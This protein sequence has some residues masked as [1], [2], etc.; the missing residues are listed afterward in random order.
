MKRAALVGVALL[1]TSALS[2]WLFLP[3]GGKGRAAARPSSKSD[4]AQ[5][6]RTTEAEDPIQDVAPA[7][8]EPRSARVEA[9]D[10]ADAAPAA[11]TAPRQKRHE[12]AAELLTRKLTAEPQDVRWTRELRGNVERMLERIEFQGSSVRSAVCG[13]SLCKIEVDHEDERAVDGFLQDARAVAGGSGAGGMAYR[14]RDADGE[15]RTVL[16]VARPGEE[17]PRVF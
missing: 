2:T 10:E 6:A 15:H 14:D 11:S 16:Y 17:L 8:T 1:L 3:Q 5:T 9:P 13:A 4:V 12:L 7:F